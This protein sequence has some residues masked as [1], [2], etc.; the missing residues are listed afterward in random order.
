[1]KIKSQFILKGLLCL[2]ASTEVGL[3]TP[4]SVDESAD[5][6]KRVISSTEPVVIAPKRAEGKSFVAT[7]VTS[8]VKPE[9]GNTAVTVTFPFAT[10]TMAFKLPSWP[11][12]VL[13]DGN[14][15][16]NAW[17]E[18]IT[19]GSSHADG[20]DYEI[21][22]DKNSVMWIE[23]QNNARIVVRWRGQ[24]VNQYGETAHT[25]VKPEAPYGAGE[26][27]DEW[28]YI[29]P[30]GVT[31]RR[32][33]IYTGYAATCQPSFYRGGVGYETQETFIEGKAGIQP[34]DIID[35]NALT[36][37][38]MTGESKDINFS[39]YPELSK[40][41]YPGANIQ[42]VNLKNGYYPFTIVAEG[43]TEIRPYDGPAI[44]RA[45]LSSTTVVTWPRQ[46]R[47]T[48]GFTSALSHVIN[49]KWHERT[50]NTVTTLYLLGVT[51]ESSKSN[52]INQ[53]VTLTRAWQ[54]SPTLTVTGDDYQS[55]GFDMKQKAY[56]LSKKSG[57][58]ANL[59]FSVAASPANPLFNPAFVVQGIDKSDAALLSVRVNGALVPDARIGVEESGLVVWVPVKS[60]EATTFEFRFEGEK[61][62]P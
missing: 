43:D 29:Y 4:A 34:T 41:M 6:A 54:Y 39:P 42:I 47:F 57:A 25:D 45:N 50:S 55:L 15:F 5:S 16:G 52:R 37:V 14:A 1:M 20:W 58:R 44:D 31:L 11:Q 48:N 7:G 49:W 62:N 22:F 17:S 23:S 10:Y 61:T 13:P 9:S 3:G 24:L 28:Y 12:Y 35:S 38:K 19:G 21:L 32:V 51:D 46:A 2:L 56:M 8:P 53:V 59:S 18:T 27:A 40:N 26:W 60:E 36:L 33:Q 30:D